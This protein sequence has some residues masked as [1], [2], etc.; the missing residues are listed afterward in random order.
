MNDGQPTCSQCGSDWLEYIEDEY[1]TGV[2]APD[3]GAE[4]RAWYGYKCRECGAMEEFTG[5]V[6]R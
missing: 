4:R 5:T 1:E 3:G 6:K 2:Y